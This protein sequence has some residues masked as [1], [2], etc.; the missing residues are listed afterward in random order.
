MPSG[1]RMRSRHAVL[2]LV[3]VASLLAAC[4]G[5]DDPEP[6][7]V[8]PSD[9]QPAAISTPEKEESDSGEESGSSRLVLSEGVI[10][11]SDTDYT[12]KGFSPRATFHTPDLAYP[13]FPELDKPRGL[14]LGGQVGALVFVNPTTVFDP[15]SGRPLAAPEDLTEWATSN[16]NLEA[17]TATPVTIAGADGMQVMAD[18]VSV[19]SKEG[20]C[21]EAC[22]RFAAITPKDSVWF[23]KGDRFRLI[24]LDVGGDAVG[25]VVASDPAGFGQVNQAANK[26][27][28]TLRFH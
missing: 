6:A 22:I 27:I 8:D 3:L 2:I 19:G 9:A 25:I 7:A 11:Q 12:T 21:D 24:S 10:T 23:L 16:D 4:G 5:A 28:K 15:A 1:V 26:L 13:F 17:S 20:D 14:V 18:V